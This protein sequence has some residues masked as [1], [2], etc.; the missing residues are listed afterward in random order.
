MEERHRQGAHLERLKAESDRVEQESRQFRSRVDRLLALPI[1]EELARAAAERQAR[2]TGL[3]RIEGELRQREAEVAQLGSMV[4]RLEQVPTAGSLLQAVAE[5][6]QRLEKLQERLAVLDD[7]R[8]RLVTGGELLDQTQA[9]L[10]RHLAEYEG[11]LRSLGKCPT[12]MQPVE[13]DLIRRILA[14]LAG[15]PVSGHSH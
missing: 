15:G 6:V 12:C 10:G 5:R 1:A 7:V 14:E 9:D 4:A 2:L 3:S 11:V 8:Q 13:P